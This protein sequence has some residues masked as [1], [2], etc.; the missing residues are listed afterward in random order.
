MNEGEDAAGSGMV[1]AGGEPMMAMEEI[2]D[3]ALHMAALPPHVNFLEAIVL[4][5]EQLYLGRG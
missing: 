2:A 5:T 1:S 3:A 4:P